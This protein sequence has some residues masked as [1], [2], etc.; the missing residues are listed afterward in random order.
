MPLIFPLFLCAGWLLADSRR[1]RMAQRASA[2]ILLACLCAWSSW[3]VFTGLNI[4][5]QLPVAWK[6]QTRETGN[7]VLGD[8]RDVVRE[9]RTRYNVLMATGGTEEEYRLTYY[10]PQLVF[11]GMPIGI[12]PAALMD[13]RRSGMAGPSL[14]RLEEEVGPK[15]I[16]WLVPR[17]GEPFGIQTLYFPHVPLFSEEFRSGFAASYTRI[18][19]S[20]YFDIYAKAN[21]PAMLR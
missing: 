5:R 1:L 2:N 6:R 4:V 18:S 16:L 12:E 17:G 21:A 11:E 15:P 3:A 14:A 7:S 9:N 19:Q 20:K 13:Y 8:L 10:R